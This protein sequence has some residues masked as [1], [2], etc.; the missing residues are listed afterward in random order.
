MDSRNNP[1][2][3]I[4]FP[5]GDKIRSRKIIS[6]SRARP[7]QKYPSWKMGRMIQAESH[8]ELN[9]YRLLDADPDAIAYHEQPLTI[10]YVLHGNVHT[11][12][13]DTLVQWGQSR[14]LWEIKPA[15]EAA[16]PAYKDR[17]RLL[18]AALPELGF[19]YRLIIAEDLARQPRL[20]TVLTLLKFGRAAAMPL[21]R[22]Q[23]RQAVEATGGIYW[24]AV[25]DGAL[26]V[27]GRNLICRLALEGVLRVDI[28]QSLTRDTWFT[29]TTARPAIAATSY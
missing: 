27:T 16:D 3:E 28:E 21:A 19:A 13:P 18:A 8:N 22:E 29:W 7:T 14:E 15:N 6:R 26:G 4:I 1:I 25:L 5:E 11:H 10:R 9:A 24:G 20:S 23:L 17:T 12:Y 2:L